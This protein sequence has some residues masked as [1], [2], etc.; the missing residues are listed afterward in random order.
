MKI[1]IDIDNAPHVQIMEPIIQ[2]LECR[3]HTVLITVRDYGHTVELLNMKQRQYVLIGKHPGKS[4]FLKA[5]FLLYRMFRLY[6]WALD[7]QIDLAFGH[8]SRSMVLPAR[9]LG[10]PVVTMYD[11]EYIADFL[12]KRFAKVILMPFLFT[13]LKDKKYILFPGLKEEIY[14]W[15]HEYIKDWDEEFNIDKNDVLVILRPPASMAH[16]HNPEAEEIFMEV[17]K[18]ISTKDGVLGLLIPRTKAQKE[19][20]IELVK[21]MG[22]IRILTKAVD[23]ISM[24]K[25]ADLVIGGGGTINREAALLGVP[26]YS[27]FQGKRGKVDKWLE[28]NERITFINSIYEVKKIQFKKKIRLQL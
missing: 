5:I 7:K 12:F 20:M 26:V 28:S 24:L 21:D 3:G 8:G 13:N 1:W 4:F 15:K 18:E 2:E 25:D 23:G 11:Y 22:G 19:E 6:L 16:Y 27:I 10:I 17:I 14:L 9:L